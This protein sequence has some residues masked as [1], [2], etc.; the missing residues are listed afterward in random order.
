MACFND[1]LYIVVNLNGTYSAS[2]RKKH[3]L[4]LL[5]ATQNNVL[6]P[7]RIEQYIAI[8]EGI[9]QYVCTLYRCNSKRY[10]HPPANGQLDGRMLC[11]PHGRGTVP[12]LE[13]TGNPAVAMV[14]RKEPVP[15]S[16][17]LTR[18]GQLHRSPD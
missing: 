10:T 3:H 1:L 17:V 18:S 5:K 13:Q 2:Q 12:D 14:P 4:F 9:Y 11:E 15:V 7:L 6:T 16:R 8:S